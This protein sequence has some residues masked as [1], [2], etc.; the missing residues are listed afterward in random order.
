MTVAP[1]TAD[2]MPPEARANSSV[3]GPPLDVFLYAGIILHTFNQ[4]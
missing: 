3:Y 4:Q 2:F 1:G